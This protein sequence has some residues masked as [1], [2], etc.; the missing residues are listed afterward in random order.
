MRLWS[1]KKE[2]LPSIC[3]AMRTAIAA[4]FSVLIARLA[5]GNARGLLGCG[6]HARHHAINANLVDRTDYRDCGGRIS[7][8]T[9][10]ELLRSKSGRVHGRVGLL[11]IAFRLEK[12][13]YR[14]ASITLAIIVLI[15]RSAPAWII[16]LHRFL[17]VSVGIIVAIAVVALWPEYHPSAA[18]RADK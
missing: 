6:C 5:G 16:A 3:H 2:D 1:W 9:R 12:T 4:T 17:E 18:K 7:G 14:Y 15:P 10:G 8:S 11:P 13:A